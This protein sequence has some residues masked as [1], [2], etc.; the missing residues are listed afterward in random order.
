MLTFDGALKEYSRI[1][2]GI[3][4]DFKGLLLGSVWI[5]RRCTIYVKWKA[6]EN[7]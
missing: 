7:I 5:P 1:S 4:E 3:K 2:N 6:K